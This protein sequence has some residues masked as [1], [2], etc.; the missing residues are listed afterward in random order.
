M[1]LLTA[2]L[3][4]LNATGSNADQIDLPLLSQLDSMCE[5]TGR[6]LDCVVRRLVALLDFGQRDPT[7]SAQAGLINKMLDA[8]THVE[9]IL[10]E[11]PAE[12]SVPGL[13]PLQ[14]LCVL[15][16][17]FG[18]EVRSERHDG[19]LDA[20]SLEECLKEL[21]NKLYNEWKG[22][23]STVDRLLSIS[24]KVL[25]EAMAHHSPSLD[26]IFV[27]AALNRRKYVGE[28]FYSLEEITTEHPEEIPKDHPG[29]GLILEFWQECFRVNKEF[30]APQRIFSF[31]LAHLKASHRVQEF[32][33]AAGA[34]AMAPYTVNTH[35]RQVVAEY[36]RRLWHHIR[37]IPCSINITGVDNYSPTAYEKCRLVGTVPV[38]TDAAMRQTPLRDNTALEPI[39]RM[40]P[41]YR[42]VPGLDL[43]EPGLR[44]LKETLEMTTFRINNPRPVFDRQPA[45]IEAANVEGRN[46]GVGVDRPPTVQ[47]LAYFD[48][49]PSTAPPLLYIFL[50]LRDVYMSVDVRLVHYIQFYSLDWGT[51]NLLN[52]IMRIIRNHSNPKVHSLLANLF[53]VPE[54]WHVAFA[55]L[56]QLILSGNADDETFLWE[57]LWAPFFQ[58][59]SINRIF[60][61][62]DG[63][64]TEEEPE[65]PS[66]FRQVLPSRRPNTQQETKNR[67]LSHFRDVARQ[68]SR[69][70]RVMA[71]Q[72]PLRY[73]VQN[74]AQTAV[75]K[76]RL[77]EGLTEATITNIVL[78]SSY[79]SAAANA[80][81]LIR[82][83]LVAAGLGGV[84]AGMPPPP[85]PGGEAEAGVAGGTGPGLAYVAT[86]QKEKL[87]RTFNELV[88][89]AMI[90]FARMGWPCAGM[91]K[92]ARNSGR[93][94]ATERSPLVA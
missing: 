55:V 22:A 37:G 10:L 38:G 16:R 49:D 52:R 63:P 28:L 12:R 7:T 8:Y 72:F 68:A 75:D 71:V 86:R 57:Y 35:E 84:V 81:A 47:P 33:N 65:E 66:V 80:L 91:V 54:L 43:S 87:T 76:S 90:L 62:S 94:T 51:L 34:L 19:S 24:V 6:S 25:E 92:Q 59:G 67:Q 83:D 40:K 15:D 60:E 26:P 1:V 77:A 18:W 21:A 32:V 27:V 50:L 3:D 31:A 46:R 88:L 70:A 13:R 5:R 56:K 11:E 41:N 36:N 30:S 45:H 14:R 85:V 29:L 82:Q 64:A 20:A 23:G 2:R 9:S 44:E 61:P 4:T 48:M 39:L 42:P 69:E 78:A 93:G 73:T 53:L 74:H 58:F 89:I 17:D 79:A